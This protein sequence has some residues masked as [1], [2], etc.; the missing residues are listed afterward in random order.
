MYKGFLGSYK[1]NKIHNYKPEPI[2]EMVEKKTIPEKEKIIEKPLNFEYHY[3]FLDETQRFVYRQICDAVCEE[4]KFICVQCKKEDVASII[5]Y[6]IDDHP[7][8]FHVSFRFAA[9]GFSPFMIFID[10]LMDGQR[11][12]DE[13]ARL[14]SS[15]PRFNGDAVHIE[16]EVRNYV[17]SKTR[18]PHQGERSSS[19]DSIY[20]VI[21][22]H[23]GTDEGIVRT[24]AFML[25][26][27]GICSSV[28]RGYVD[29]SPHMWNVVKIG[30]SYGHMDPAL[31]VGDDGTLFY[32]YFNLT[33]KRMSMTHK[34]D[35]PTHCNDP[36]IRYLGEN[37]CRASDLIE[38]EDRISLM[39]RSKKRDFSIFMIGNTHYAR[40]TIMRTAKET[41]RKN[42][43]SDS[44]IRLMRCDEDQQVF[45]F[46]VSQNADS[47]N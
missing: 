2:P 16:K 12:K 28:I 45:V 21:T 44:E 36:L 34:W 29:N 42:G 47:L 27:N 26:I 20:G 9:D 38:A 46:S 25:N 6:V 24:I 10:Y 13:N 32:V 3:Q 37:S 7:L 30:N 11:Y 15:V 22:E 39:I 18:H 4:K 33:D 14:C 8:F 1:G 23:V 17:L 31:D 43:I 5:E 40:E 35:F 41:L 19:T